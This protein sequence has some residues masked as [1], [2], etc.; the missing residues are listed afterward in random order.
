MA[1]IDLSIL[2]WV[3]LL[4]AIL[5]IDHL[6]CDLLVETSR[7][8]S[9]GYLER[10]SQASWGLNEKVHMQKENVQETEARADL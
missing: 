9:F 5:W 8:I 7:R 6:I 4:L 3:K 1:W 2:G 10:Q